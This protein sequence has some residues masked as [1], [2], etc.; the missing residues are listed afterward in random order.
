MNRFTPCDV[1]SSFRTVYSLSPFNIFKI[2]QG[3]LLNNCQYRH[4]TKFQRHKKIFG[5]TWV[6][7]P[8]PLATQFSSLRADF[9]THLCVYPSRDF[10]HAEVFIFTSFKTKSDDSAL[11]RHCF[12]HCSF[13]IS[14]LEHIEQPN[15]F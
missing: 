12:V 5:E 13:C 3:S 14:M 11:S 7:H 4:G 8:W 2:L 9:I 10:V 1:L 15:S 6:S